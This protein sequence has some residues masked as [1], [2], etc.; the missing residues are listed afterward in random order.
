MFTLQ[1]I[2]DQ[3]FEENQ[4]ETSNSSTDAE[5][6]FSRPNAQIFVVNDSTLLSLV[7]LPV[8][9]DERRFLQLSKTQVR[10][11]LR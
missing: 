3:I 2:D 8:M 9:E 7:E 1:E 4:I 10:L 6:V 5:D 11:I